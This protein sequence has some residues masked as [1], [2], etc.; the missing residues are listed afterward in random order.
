M[1]C[2]A[3]ALILLGPGRALPLHGQTGQTPAPAAQSSQL[4]FKTTTSLVEVDVV[5][6]DQERFVPGLTADD[7]ALYEDG[8][9]QTIQQFYMVTHDS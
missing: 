5:V 2:G 4:T 9:P 6:L 1:F 7:L 3:A 8:K